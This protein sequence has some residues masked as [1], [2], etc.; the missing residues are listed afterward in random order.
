MNTK[1]FRLDVKAVNDEGTFDGMLSVYGNLDLGGDVVERGAFTKTLH[2]GGDVRPLLWQHDQKQ[3]IGTLRLRDTE[4]GLECRGALVMGVTRG[5]EAH[6]LMKAGALKGLSI[7]FDTI[8]SKAA[9]DGKGVRRLKE[10][11]L[12]EGSLVTFPMNQMA[13]VSSVKSDEEK[14]G[15]RFSAA[16]RAAILK[17]ISNNTL[18]NSELQALLDSEDMEPE[19][20]TKTHEPDPHSEVKQLT[21][22]N[23]QLKEVLSWNQASMSK[24]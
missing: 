9:I 10:I 14:S 1:D 19:A 20:A 21:E 22:L 6:E 15:R 16:S 12:W 11:R 18:S 8:E 13:Q 24:R 2:D 17:I 5:R 23:D 4:V 3:P 7:G